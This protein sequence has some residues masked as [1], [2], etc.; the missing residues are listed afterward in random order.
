MILRSNTINGPGP[1]NS[2]PA[3]AALRSSR[4]Y[5]PHRFYWTWWKH[6]PSPESIRW[7]RPC[8][9]D[10][11]RSQTDHQMTS[12]QCLPSQNSD[13]HDLSREPRKVRER[14]HVLSME[15]LCLSDLQQ[16]TLFTSLLP[17]SPTKS[18]DEREV[19]SMLMPHVEICI[20]LLFHSLSHRTTI[21]DK[22]YTRF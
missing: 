4:K 1:F 2:L 18:S 20:L 13:D 7:H 22:L 12:F 6:N 21:T 14:K 10:H 9:M 17:Y 3:A 15:F 19:K 11:R 16:Q 5:F 8:R